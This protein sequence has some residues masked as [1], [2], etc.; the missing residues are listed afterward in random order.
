MNINFEGSVNGEKFTDLESFMNAL[1]AIKD[2]NNCKDISLSYKTSWGD[3][4][5]KEEV[6][7]GLSG[8]FQDKKRS[9]KKPRHFEPSKIVEDFDFDQLNGT[10][11][12]EEIQD[13]LSTTLCNKIEE[14]ED[15]IGNFTIDEL[16]GYAKINDARLNHYDQLLKLNLGKITQINDLIESKEQEITKLRKS[17]AICEHVREAQTDLVDYHNAIKKIINNWI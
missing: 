16:E 8:M 10:D 11:K 14:F 4:D 15:E 3:D 5:T 12:D 1:K 17:L 6:K 2:D 7:N 9:L 13:D